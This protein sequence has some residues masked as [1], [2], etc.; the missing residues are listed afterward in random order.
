MGAERV[1]LQTRI[2]AKRLTIILGRKYRRKLESKALY[3]FG[4]VPIVEARGG[5]GAEGVR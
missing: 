3:S 2:C 4:I 1:N 5:G